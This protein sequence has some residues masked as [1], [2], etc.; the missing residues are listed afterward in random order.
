MNLDFTEEQEMLKNS[1]RDFLSTEC[2]KTLVKELE[3]DEKGYSPDIWKKMAE[4]GWMGLVIPEDYDGMGME[5]MDLVLLLQEM[6]RN[7]LPGPFFST[8]VLGALPIVAAG[9]EAQKKELLPK[10]ANGEAIVTMA[11]VEPSASY[12]PSGVSLKATAQG[13]SYVLEGTKLFVENAHI[14]DYI[15]VVARTKEGTAEAGITVFICDGKA[16]GIS[17]TV[18][19]T[20]GADKQCE[21]VFSKVSVPKTAILGELDKGWPIVARALE[22]ATIARCAEM[23]GGCEAALD[24]TVAYSKDRVQYGK[25]ISSFQVL[26]H[27]MANMVIYLETARNLIYE[28]AWMVSEGMPCSKLV[29]ATKGWANQAYKFIT[30]RSV[31]IHGAIGTTRD[32]DIGLYYRRALSAEFNFGNGEVQREAIA[33]QLGI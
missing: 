16:P 23:L 22:Q 26:Q 12:E 19:P 30:E 15:L 11:L 10:I 1:A 5:F 2:P 4:L 20:I 17:S 8:A 9:S 27:Y 29:A 28:T 14:A 25:P 3:E 7:I 24:M 13:D 33:R 6:G 18:I 31:H 32:H 21:V